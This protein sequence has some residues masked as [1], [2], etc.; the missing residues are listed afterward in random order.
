[1]INI[2]ANIWT[3]QSTFRPY[4][5]SRRRKDVMFDL[6]TAGKRAGYAV[7]TMGATVFDPRARYTGE[8]QALSLSNQFTARITLESNR[9]AGILVDP[10][11]MVWWLQQ[12]K[13]AVDEA[14]GGT[15]TLREA[16]VAFTAW[17]HE[18]APGEEGP[19][20]NVWSHGAGFDQ[21][22]LNHAYEAL[23]MQAPWPYNA[24]RDT[25]TVFDMADIHYKGV[26]HKSLE[27]AMEQALAV[28]KAF[29][30]LGLST[31][32]EPSQLLAA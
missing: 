26:A 9:A 3:I 21:P 25:R 19:D 20:V 18:V 22:I 30:V 32:F 23:G 28:E 8:H 14:F 27:D 31:A 13:E 15:A 10:A 4:A 2:D 24:G 1:M 17:L 12:S 5:T 16:L 29:H 11:T 7:L 6:E